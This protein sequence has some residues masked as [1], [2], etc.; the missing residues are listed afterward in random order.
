MTAKRLP[1]FDLDQAMAAPGFT[2]RA[3]DVPALVA[4]LA[5]G[6]EAAEKAEKALLRVARLAAE[7]TARQIEGAS[8][9]AKPRLLR[10]AG[11][12]ASREHGEVLVPALIAALGSENE[13]GR[14]AAATALGKLCLTVDDGSLADTRA[15]ALVAALGREGETPARRAMI[16][17][18]GKVGGARAIPVLGR[19]A[20]QAGAGAPAEKARLIATRTA[21]RTEPSKVDPGR[22]PPAP[23]RVALRCRAGLE[24]L[25]ASELPKSFQPRLLR[26]ALGG[27]RVE[28]TLDGPIEGLF[29][30]RLMLSFGFVLPPIR[31]KNEDD[32]PGAIARSLTS[33]EALGLLRGLT[34]GPIR[35]RL[36]WASG[37]KRRAAIWKAAAEVAA[38]EPAL[39]NDPTE[40]PWEATVAE[41][42]GMV[43][44]EL[45]P[46]LDDPRFAYRVGDVPAASH[47]T[48]AAALCRVAGARAGDVVWDPFVGSGLELCERALGGPYRLLI[49]SDR[50]P[51]A[52]R[53]AAKN[54]ASAKVPEDKI[55]LLP[56]DAT[57]MVP[58]ARPS[59]IITNPP[60]GR[61]VSR[62]AELAPMLDRFIANA[63]KNLSPGGRLVWIAP[64]PDQSDK[65]ARRAGLE[66]YVGLDVDLGGFS[67]RLQAFRKPG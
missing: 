59:L 42:D 11:K 31:M 24:E 50:D 23:L 67:A 49:G 3:A 35:Y 19:V 60:L 34:E 61:R 9:E 45:S 33:K 10:F 7:E 4:R 48:I 26:D 14:R 38:I 18:L 22:A 32:L 2:P 43:R 56:G 40:S 54:L 13:P 17:A 25:M 1:G 44:V 36:G 58:P 30:S 37:G 63:A 39:I 53:V 52:L 8:R 21:A 62:S 28:A 57:T 29:R 47:P 51:E 6:G 55:R 16:E 27:T 66:A 5:Q 12:V 64:F 65:V 15:D 46:K 41:A 20:E